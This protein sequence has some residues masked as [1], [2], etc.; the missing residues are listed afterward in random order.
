MQNLE[1]NGAKQG[2]QIT[3]TAICLAA[4]VVVD[5]EEGRS[6]SRAQRARKGSRNR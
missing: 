6:R 1:I 3:V 4:T 2:H 5:G